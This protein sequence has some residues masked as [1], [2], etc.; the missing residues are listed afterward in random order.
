[1]LLE[2][3]D[4]LSPDPSGALD[5]RLESEDGIV[6]VSGLPEKSGDPWIGK[7]NVLDA[8]TISEVL[9]ALNPQLARNLVESSSE[10]VQT[11]GDSDPR[12]TTYYTYVLNNTATKFANRRI[13]KARYFPGASEEPP[14]E[15]RMLPVLL[16]VEKH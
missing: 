4:L 15:A 3:E 12:G 9:D 2:E 11:P 16:L 10:T 1:G 6:L 13:I 14:L 8:G 7:T 5:A